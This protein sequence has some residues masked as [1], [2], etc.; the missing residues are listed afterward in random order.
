MTSV[1]KQAALFLKWLYEKFCNKSTNLFLPKI[2]NEVQFSI[3][4]HVVTN[5]NQEKKTNNFVEMRRTDGCCVIV[6]Q[7]KYD[8]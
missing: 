2:N 4:F 8:L 6:V 1:V 3:Y 7:G 5:F